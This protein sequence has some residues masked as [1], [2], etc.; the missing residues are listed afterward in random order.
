MK[1]FVRYS[2][3]GVVKSRRYRLL[4]AGVILSILLPVL[5]LTVTE[6]LFATTREKRLDI[7]GEFS[8]L[9]YTSLS[10]EETA[11]L[12]E[13]GAYPSGLPWQGNRENTGG[14]YR[15]GEVGYGE[16]AALSGGRLQ[17]EEGVF[18]GEGQAAVTRYEAER[19]G[20]SLGG[21]V[22]TAAGTF[23][24]S[25]ILRDYG[26]LWC[27]NSSQTA[28]Q[29]E[30]PQIL[31]CREDFAAWAGSQP[32]AEVTVKYMA[33]GAEVASGQYQADYNLVQNE[34]I[35]HSSFQVPQVILWLTYLCAGILLLQLMR[36]GLPGIGEKMRVYRLIGVPARQIPGLF[37]LDLF[38]LYLLAL[39][40]GA[41]G[42][43]ALA[44]LFCAAG[45]WLGETEIL[46]SLT[47]SYLLGAVGI[48]LLLMFL[49]GLGPAFA[50]SRVS[51]LASDPGST[52][53]RRLFPVLT[54]LFLVGVFLLYG[55]SR[56]YL[57]FYQDQNL[58]LPVFGKLAS[59][60]DYE[61]LASRVS[62]DTSYMDE[63]GYSLSPSVMEEG[64]VMFLY[65]AAF[66]GAT[67]QELEE[68]AA[69]SGVRRVAGYKENTELYMQADPADSYQTA[70]NSLSGGALQPEVTEFFGMEGD[71]MDTSLAGYSDEELLS[72]QPYVTEGEIDL[73][74]LR[75]GEEVILVAPD[76]AIEELT[77]SDGLTGQQ[78]IFLEPGGYT[79][80]PGQYRAAGW[81]VG[82]AVT[83]TE[84]ASE[85]PELTGFADMEIIR[86]ELERKDYTVRIGAII[87]S[88]VGWFED[89]WRPDPTFRFLTSNQAFD[90]LGM[91]RTYDRVRVYGEAGAD[92]VQMEET[93]LRFAAAHPDMSFDNRYSRMVEYRQ[94]FWM[95]SILA[96]TL[97]VLAV[98]MGLVMLGSQLLLQVTENRK[99]YGLYQVAGVTRRRLLFRTAVPVE[100]ACALA[101]LAS[102]FLGSRL[103]EHFWAL[104]D[105]YLAQA[106]GAVLLPA[107]LALA[108]LAMVPAGK[109]LCRQSIGA[110]LK[111]DE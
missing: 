31:L 53:R 40:V 80:A 33:L 19:Q 61:L 42:G 7:Y 96:G 16:E 105:S 30:N 97:S 71:W 63:N 24:V 100:A 3:Y 36:M 58:S 22:S 25:G 72:F 85:H 104:G 9:Y 89:S 50:L 95:L 39:P 46:F 107:A 56:C 103:A 32:E 14:L 44:F 86:K 90:V 108:G 17:L 110:L 70:R 49:A 109:Y 45:S 111:A 21:Q 75:S 43:V 74:K 4:F 98:F 59:D 73:E 10:G 47:P 101:W 88:R 83:L 51:P 2:F 26:S 37:A 62:S 18:P 65:N 82:E 99:W 54:G 91:E 13:T 78:V 48:S 87:R 29:R 76:L 60:Y 6:S 23:T 64:D 67:D 15:L 11:E 35:L 27:S 102:L 106:H 12:L 28:E 84:L 92:P 20:L 38:W 69:S 81:Q 94:Y 77:F 5:F 52:R 55:S 93:M 79:G 34:P 57:R 1:V 41:A 8:D 66:N 68:L